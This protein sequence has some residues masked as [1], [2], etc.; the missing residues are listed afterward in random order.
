MLLPRG[1]SRSLLRNMSE[2][3]TPKLWRGLTDFFKCVRTLYLKERDLRDTTNKQAKTPNILLWPFKNSPKIVSMERSKSEMIHDRLVVGIR[4]S[5]LSERLQLDAALDLEKA[6]RQREAVQEQQ[7][8]LQGS[9]E[10]STSS[11]RALWPGRDSRRFAQRRSGQSQNSR[12]KTSLNSK[13]TCPHSETN[14]PQ[15]TQ[16]VIVARRKGTMALCVI[17]KLLIPWRWT[18][19]LLMS[20]S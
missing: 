20:C 1:R 6:I 8:T 2:K 19:H 16:A 7:Q 3:T 12:G 11:I 10:P 5:A 17:Q 9:Q 4:D 13:R 14:V 18:S 15:G